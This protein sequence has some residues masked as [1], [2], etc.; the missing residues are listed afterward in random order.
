[1]N[2]V[3]IK[4]FHSTTSPKPCNVHKKDGVPVLFK[5]YSRCEKYSPLMGL[6]GRDIYT[7]LENSPK[8]ACVPIG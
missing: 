1:M 5:G 3:H 7:Y 6:H 2:P 4:L 8:K